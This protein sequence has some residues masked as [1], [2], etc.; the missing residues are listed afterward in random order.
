MRNLH[1]CDTAMEK[2][3]W[4]KISH[5][6]HN[7]VECSGSIGKYIKEIQIEVESSKYT[8]DY[9]RASK[10]G[11][12]QLSEKRTLEEMHHETWETI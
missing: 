3:S 6:I 9:I 12:T 5:E 10:K 7:V 8:Y 11:S 4:K 2:K 1:L